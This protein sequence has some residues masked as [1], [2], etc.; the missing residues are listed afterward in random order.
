[1]VKQSQK[2]ASQWRL[3]WLVKLDA[4]IERADRSAIAKALTNLERFGVEV[5]FT[6]P[7]P[8]AH[9]PEHA[10]VAKEGQA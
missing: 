6:I 9:S 8:Q 1:M 4:A 7:I 2:S 3:W 5:R 10:S